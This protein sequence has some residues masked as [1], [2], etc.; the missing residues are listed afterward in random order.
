LFAKLFLAS[1]LLAGCDR[2]EPL[3]NLGTIPEFAL[4]D[5]DERPFDQSMLDG[6]ITIASFVFTTCPSVCPVLSRRSEE[7]Q[8]S[9]MPR[10]DDVQLVAF[11]V[12]PD[13]DTPAVLRAYRERYHAD[14]AIW[15]HVTG[16]AD[17]LNRVVVHG[18]H[19]AMGEERDSAGEILHS[20]HFVLVDRHRNIRGY[21]EADQDGTDDLVEAV[22]QLLRETNQPRQ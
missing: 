15:R 12:D 8:A 1:V 2:S 9:F 6:K 11:S 22:E 21:F 14:A 16:E 17:E 13:H 4:V 19:L 3:P 20:S 7:L 10:N 18:F 5:Q